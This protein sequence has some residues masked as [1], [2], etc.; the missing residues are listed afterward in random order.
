MNSRPRFDETQKKVPRFRRLDNENIKTLESTFA[1]YPF[2]QGRVEIHLP[3][4]KAKSSF[5]NDTIWVW[6]KFDRRPATYLVFQEDQ[7]TCIWDPSRQEGMTLRWLLPPGFCSKGPTICL[8]NLLAGESTI[9]IEDLLVYEGKDLW[10]TLKFSDRW[11]K[12]RSIWTRLPA[13][14]PLL[15]VTPRIV[16]P[17]SLQEWQ[18][19]YDSSL[20]W[21]FQPE[22]V[23]S[24][25]WYWWDSVTKVEKKEYIP[26]T[27]TR[28]TEVMTLLCA[29]C[30]PYTKLGLPDTYILECQE[31]TPIGI[32]GIA[33]LGL[34][35]ILRS[36]MLPTGIPVEVIWNEEFGKYQIVR[37]LPA[38]SIISSESF[39]SRS[40]V[41]NG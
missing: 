29:L 35:K 41:G 14:Q 22:V 4:N 12:L 13:D 7:P 33:T 26:P 10:S 17:F 5:A 32:A 6:P 34:S 9:Q 24:P 38:G 8:A 39:F 11:E 28:R 3:F 20:S 25:R 2:L 31:G 21:I 37:T 30:K 15:S 40:T 36:E 27:L 19:N 23:R 18:E 1:D 16:K